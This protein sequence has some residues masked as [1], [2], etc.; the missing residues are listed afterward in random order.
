MDAWAAA[1]EF[2]LD[3]AAMGLP[4]A[5]AGGAFALP[6]VFVL[7]RAPRPFG[8]PNTVTT[9][10]LVLLALV[11][12]LLAT[13]STSEPVPSRAWLA[14]TLAALAIALDGLDGWLARRFGPDTAFGA[15]YDMETDAGLILAMCTYVVA[16]G[17]L[18]AWILLSGLMRYAFLAAGWL[19]PALAAPLPPSFRRKAVCVVQLAALVLLVAP[20]LEG[21]GAIVVGA[22]SLGLL[23]WSFA[24]DV[25]WLLRNRPAPA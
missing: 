16:A 23:A 6:A 10:R 3:E 2:G 8:W 21:L 12:G 14:A 22:G 13:E 24:V 18:E 4:L 15:R 19:W 11:C 1:A 25:G 20:L 5:V 9:V 7:L 17:R